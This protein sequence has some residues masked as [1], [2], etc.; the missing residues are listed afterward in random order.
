MVL[1][2]T[3]TIPFPK[4]FSTTGILNFSDNSRRETD[5]FVIAICI[6]ICLFSQKQKLEQQDS[7]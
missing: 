5:A 1:Q 3:R 2:E 7:V 6:A 4:I